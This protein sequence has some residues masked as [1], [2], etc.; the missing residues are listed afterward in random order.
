MKTDQ[1]SESTLPKC[2]LCDR[3]LL[4]NGRVVDVGGFKK[5]VE[6]GQCPLHGDVAPA[7]ADELK[8]NN[9]AN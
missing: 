4:P 6:P 3:A 1:T 5:W 9:S 8:R 7:Q 2:A